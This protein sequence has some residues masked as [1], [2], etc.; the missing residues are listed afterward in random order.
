MPDGIL[1]LV[2]LRFTGRKK[3]P[4]EGT[5]PTKRFG[6]AREIAGKKRYRFHVLF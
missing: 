4:L 6:P 5:W 3:N 1:P 2:V